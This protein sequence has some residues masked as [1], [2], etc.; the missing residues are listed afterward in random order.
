MFCLFSGGC[1][2]P[3]F[4]SYHILCNG[5][6][7]KMFPIMNRYPSTYPLWCNGGCTGPN[8]RFLHLYLC[9]GA[10]PLGSSHIPMC[11]LY[12]IPYTHALYHSTSIQYHHSYPYPLN[13]RNTPMAIPPYT[14]SI[15]HRKPYENMPVDRLY[16]ASMA[17]IYGFRYHITWRPERVDIYGVVEN[18]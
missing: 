3:E 7:D 12:V 17:P 4:M 16:T 5:Q 13:S 8:T 2:F 9:I 14:I 11:F 18:L 1:K 6:S 15:Y 10:L